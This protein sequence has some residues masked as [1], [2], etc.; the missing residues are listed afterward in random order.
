MAMENMCCK[1]IAFA[2]FHLYFAILLFFFFFFAKQ[3]FL[4]TFIFFCNTSVLLQV[5]VALIWLHS[6]HKAKQ[7]LKN[8]ECRS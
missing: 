5:S 7:V 6:F 3:F 1:I 4:N 8:K 2:L